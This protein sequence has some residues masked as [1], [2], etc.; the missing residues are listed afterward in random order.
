MNGNKADLKFSVNR[1]KTK[2]IVSKSD[3]ESIKTI[4][5]DD[6]KSVKV[7]DDIFNTKDTKDQNTYDSSSNK[8]SDEQ[9]QYSQ[10]RS[11]SVKKVNVK[12]LRSQI[13][14]RSL[15]LKEIE[16]QSDVAES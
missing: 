4:E 5:I 1:G 16:V 7:V 14:K 10:I 3:P 13:K 11:N 9:S 6:V 8:S 12:E 2:T 15:S